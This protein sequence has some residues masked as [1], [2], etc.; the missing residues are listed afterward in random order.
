MRQH[1]DAAERAVFLSQPSLSAEIHNLE[2]EMGVTAFVAQ[3]KGVTVTQEARSCFRLRA[4]CSSR[5]TSLQEHFGVGKKRCAQ[6]LR[7]MSATNSF[8][9]NAFGSRLSRKYDADQYGF[10]LRGKRR[11]VS[12]HDWMWR[13]AKAKLGLLY[14][15]ESNETRALQAAAHKVRL[16]FEE[17][18]QLPHRAACGSFNKDQPLAEYRKCITLDEL[19]ALS[20]I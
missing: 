17:L 11:P 5:Q 2:K 13:R 19:K 14:L 6:D 9:V 12:I 20:R 16:V 4:C 8:A 3:T 1:H 7:V 15:S 10:I 18:Y